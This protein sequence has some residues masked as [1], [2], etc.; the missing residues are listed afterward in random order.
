M[1][2]PDF[3]HLLVQEEHDGLIVPL[4]DP[5]IF[6]QL[7]LMF[8]FM[9]SFL[10]VAIITILTLYNVASVITEYTWSLLTPGNQLLEITFITTSIVCAIIMLLSFKCMSDVLDAG[11]TKLKEELNTKERRIQELELKLL[12]VE[13]DTSKKIVI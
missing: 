13:E 4:V 12:L 9:V 7:L 8:I 5:H 1:F 11:F 3:R 6:I 10:S 2:N